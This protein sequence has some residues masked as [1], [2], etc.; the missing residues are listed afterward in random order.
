[1]RKMLRDDQTYSRSVYITRQKRYG[2]FSFLFDGMMTIVTGGLWFI[3][4]FVREMR[5]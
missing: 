3:W 4:I 2:F 1:M 5:R